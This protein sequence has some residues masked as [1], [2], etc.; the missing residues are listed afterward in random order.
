MCAHSTIARNEP[1]LHNLSHH[2]GFPPP[3][4]FKLAKVDEIEDSYDVTRPVSSAIGG[5]HASQIVGGMFD[6]YVKEPILDFIYYLKNDKSKYGKRQD[7][8]KK[9]I[10]LEG[11]EPNPGPPRKD[12]KLKKFEKK[13]NNKIMKKVKRAI[14][15][16]GGT[17]SGP[18][19][20]LRPKYGPARPKGLMSR[21]G[22]RKARKRMSLPP[23]VT[24][25]NRPHDMT[26]RSKFN[27]KNSTQ[28]ILRGSEV[29]SV[30]DSFSQSN[31]PTG[32]ILKTINLN[33][34]QLASPFIV[35]IAACFEK[36]FFTSFRVR[37]VTN[38]SSD[39]FGGFR[40]YFEDDSDNVPSNSGDTKS[41]FQNACRHP[42]TRS[43]TIYDNNIVFPCPYVDQKKMGIMERPAF[44]TD[45]KE[46]ARTSIQSVFCLMVENPCKTTFAYNVEIEYTLK[47]WNPQEPG[48]P[49]NVVTTLGSQ[50]IMNNASTAVANDDFFS[51]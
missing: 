6:S 28:I 48:A 14:K 15:K 10:V 49:G 38:Q 21:R 50:L 40:G 20:V 29:Y 22:V 3:K 27:G 18:Y 32:T 43:F 7:S 41:N 31:T 39:N 4:G 23:G 2:G 35:N 1:M 33:P 26:T 13:Q 34:S 42:S 47:L 5:K 17:V 24:H 9:Q 12:K 37:V 44:F 51:C 46:G 11:V 19:S 45:L 30:G 25:L 8:P 16:T 36:F